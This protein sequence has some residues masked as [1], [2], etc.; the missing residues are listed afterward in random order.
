MST[1]DFSTLNTTLPHTLIK[2]KNLDL[3]E[4]TFYKKEGKLYLACND[5]KAFSLLQTII[6]DITFGLVRMYVTPYLLDNIYIRFGT[7]LSDKSFVFRWIQI[8][9]LL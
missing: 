9:L 6:E 1:Y 8:V 4:R 5:K 3:I 2:E 7:K